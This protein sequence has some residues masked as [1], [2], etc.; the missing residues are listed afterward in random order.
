MYNE[1]EALTPFFESVL[2]ILEATL[3]SFEI[4]CINDGSSDDTYVKLF[5]YHRSD[6]RIKIVDLS[7]NFGKEAA[8]TAGIDLAVGRAVLPMD[9]D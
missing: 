3:E 2:P 5:H 4:I 6:P 9:A 1:S 8:I 7:R